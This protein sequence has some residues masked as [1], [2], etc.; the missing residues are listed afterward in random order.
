MEIVITAIHSEISSSV[1]SYARDKV[2][3]LD[4]YFDK[5]KKTNVNIHA[6]PGNYDVELI[7][8]ANHHTFTVNVHTKESVQEAIDLAVDKMSTQLKRSKGKLKGHKGKERRK[9]LAKD[10]KRVT[11]RLQK[12]EMVARKL[13]K[14]VGDDGFFNKYEEFFEAADEAK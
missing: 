7:C 2:S 11:Q 10:I 5:A 14:E 1:K 3:R 4:K 9:K 13:E 8:N 12:L 6:E